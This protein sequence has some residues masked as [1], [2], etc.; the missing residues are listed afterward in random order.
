MAYTYAELLDIESAIEAARNAGKAMGN[1][2][3]KE[4]L[5]NASYIM[6]EIRLTKHRLNIAKSYEDRHVYISSLI[7]MFGK[8][9]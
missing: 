3:M 8:E 7:S 4:R 9:D 1:D 6:A 2:Q 5:A